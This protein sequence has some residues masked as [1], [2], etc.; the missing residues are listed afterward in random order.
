MCSESEPPPP[1]ICPLGVSASEPLSRPLPRVSLSPSLSLSLIMISKLA[2][3]EYSQP[4]HHSKAGA[5]G[6][7]VVSPLCT[8]L[9]VATLGPLGTG[10]AKWW[11]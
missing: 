9:M 6:S 7:V 3:V 10:G 5:P 11:S 2:E 8:Q 4:D 1:T